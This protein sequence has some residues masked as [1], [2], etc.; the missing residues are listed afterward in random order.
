VSDH[1][2]I[3]HVAKLAERPRVC[4]QESEE[5]PRDFTKLFTQELF[6]VGSS[7]VPHVLHAYKELEVKHEQL[8]LIEPNFETPLPPL[9]P[10]VFPPT[11]RELGPP[12]LDLF[13]LDDSF[14][15]EQV[16]LNQL[17]N[18]CNED[19]LEYFVREAGDIL[20][21][22]HRLDPAKRDGKHVLE[23]VLRQ[24]VQFKKSNQ[25]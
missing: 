22:T 25:D 23:Y 2:H 13:D 17:T 14:S 12:A 10:A 9:R 24:L 4:L 15:S 16:R 3:P 18:K 11:F 21:I 1:T 8:K 19:D 7:M 6:Q 20:G 5:M